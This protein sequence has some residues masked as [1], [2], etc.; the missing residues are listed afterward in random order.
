MLCHAQSRTTLDQRGRWTV[1]LRTAILPSRALARDVM[2]L[3]ED[4]AQAMR[5]D[6]RKLGQRLCSQFTKI[7]ERLAS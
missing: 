1:V 7:R 2:V 4:E 6:L 3:T 5:Q